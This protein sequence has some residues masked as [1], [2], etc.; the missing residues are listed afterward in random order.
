MARVQIQADGAQA[1]GGFPV[2]DEGNYVLECVDVVDG[3]TKGNPEIGKPSRQKVDLQFTIMTE[4]GKAVGSLWH[5]LTIIPDREKGHGM[6]LHANH[7]LGLPYDG[8]LDYDTSEYRGKV[9][10]AHVV[11]DEYPVGS[12]KR[13]NKVSEF[14]VE[15]AEP[16]APAVQKKAPEAQPPNGR[17]KAVP[18]AGELI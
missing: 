11:I 15:D 3:M 4:E 7:A 18:K 2:V 1:T 12:G 8:S 6:W 17:A 14:Y 9:C 10:R 5:T 13:R 16:A